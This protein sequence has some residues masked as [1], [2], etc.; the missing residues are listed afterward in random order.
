MNNPILCT[1]EDG[2]MHIRMNRPEKKNALTHEMYSLMAD[3]I[4][5]ADNAADIRVTLISGSDECFTSGN[6]VMDFMENPPSGED[7]PVFRLLRLISTAQKPIIAAV[8][9]P[10]VGIGTT[11]LLHCDLAYAGDNAMLQ[12]PFVNLALCPEAAS[13]LLV[14][15]MIGQRKAAELLLL[16]EKMDAKTACELGF[17]NRVV[18]S[19]QCLPTALEAAQKI[20]KLAPSSVRLTKR[21]M[22]ENQAQQVTD[23][24]STEAV[25]FGKRL[26]S[27]E[28]QEAFQAFLQ[29]RPADF[30]RFE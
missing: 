29:K 7:A 27:E 28:A 12:M 30:S 21:L 15:Q 10:A 11:M 1:T 20:A 26:T 25:E 4:E 18:S 23:V 3:A 8:N 2:I 6:D 14:P 9:G 16:G 24:I 5:Q 22:K 19:D 17:I 13:S